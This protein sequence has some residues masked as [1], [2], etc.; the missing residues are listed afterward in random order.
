MQVWTC[1]QVS[2]SPASVI[3][4]CRTCFWIYRLSSCAFFRCTLLRWTF[5]VVISKSTICSRPTF[6][7]SSTLHAC[8]CSFSA[9][10]RSTCPW[11][12]YLCGECIVSLI[13]QQLAL[14]L[15]VP[16][17]VENLFGTLFC[18]FK[19]QYHRLCRAWHFS[20]ENYICFSFSVFFFFEFMR[21]GQFQNI[22]CSSAESDASFSANIYVVLSVNQLV[23]FHK[24]IESARS[25]RQLDWMSCPLLCFLLIFNPYLGRN[26]LLMLTLS[27]GF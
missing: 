2:S 25:F 23:I 5:C 9:S 18:L 12:E 20:L 24:S 26:I 13:E 27:S 10:R 1:M 6:S 7:N 14:L 3:W 17:S 21:W 15:D 16:T 22:S 19:L 4:N 8:S 11:L